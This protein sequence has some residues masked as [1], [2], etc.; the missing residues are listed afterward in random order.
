ME[1][2]YFVVNDNIVVADCPTHELAA[3]VSCC[4]ALPHKHY[5]LTVSAIEGIGLQVSGGCS[6][7]AD[8]NERAIVSVKEYLKKFAPQYS[9]SH[10]LIGKQFYYQKRFDN[11]SRLYTV[12]RVTGSGKTSEGSGALFEC[13]ALKGEYEPW[14][15]FVARRVIMYESELSRMTLT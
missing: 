3:K 4:L 10:A 2:R 8:T 11:Q 12:L 14:Q 9:S 5:R 7:V 15:Y 1:D 6:S 13:L